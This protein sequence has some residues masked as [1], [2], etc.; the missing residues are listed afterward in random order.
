MDTSSKNSTDGI[1]PEMASVKPSGPR[2]SI[3]LAVHNG[4][5]FLRAAIESLLAQDV[6]DLELI[7]SDNASTDATPSICGE[8]AAVDPRISYSRNRTNIGAAANF[9]RV[10]ELSAGEFFM[11]GS[12]DDLWD[13]SFARRCIDMLEARPQAV[14]CTSLVSLIGEDGR[15]R[16]ETYDSADTTGMTVEQRV[17][18]LIRRF[19]W[20]DM[21]S[22]IRPAALRKTGLFAPSYGGDV[23]LLLELSLLGEFVRV[24]EPLFTYRLP[25]QSKSS[26]ALLE[27]IGVH[28]DT[29]EQQRE[30]AGFLAR[31]LLS[32]VK[33]A[34]LSDEILQIISAD[35]VSTLGSEDSRLG[36]AILHER[37]I[38]PLPAWAAQYEI[39]RALAASQSKESSEVRA[40][41]NA[42]AM[43]E[44]MRL[45]AIRRILLRLLRPFTTEQHE[46]DSAQ[47]SSMAILA[48]EVAL[49]R[50][51]LD[52]LEGGGTRTSDSD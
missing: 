50:S 51:R 4:E 26:E 8:F 15:P 37:G 44:G 46:L 39:V 42:W 3:G 33:S 19:P 47:S 2:L 21:Y 27:E 13:P 38:P 43:R 5:R 14:L 45:D 9:N 24:E 22:V 10:F 23:R 18:D 30:S 20:Y 28:S 31:D 25:A 35:F 36:R 32:V 41:R 40:P 52:E 6:G 1:A 49:L 17:H 11:W 7:I 29:T 48:E 34:G 12:D 16:S